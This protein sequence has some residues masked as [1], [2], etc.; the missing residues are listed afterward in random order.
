MQKDQLDKQLDEMISINISLFLTM[1]CE[2]GI[3]ELTKG[4]DGLRV[5]P[6][7]NAVVIVD[8]AHNLVGRIV[9]ITR[10]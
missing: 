6:F 1:D 10:K 2:K 9:N 7:D 8:E 3:T 4:S 5:N